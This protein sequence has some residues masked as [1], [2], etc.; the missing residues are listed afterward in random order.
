MT[1]LE[2]LLRQFTECIEEDY[3]SDVRNERLEGVLIRTRTHLDWLT[4]VRD[5]RKARN[6]YWLQVNRKKGDA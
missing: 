3:P 4:E 1:K 2:R 5:H 6:E